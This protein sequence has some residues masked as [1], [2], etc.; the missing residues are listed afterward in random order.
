MNYN[1]ATGHINS[2]E[3][4]QSTVIRG[5]GAVAPADKR[6]SSETCMTEGPY[7]LASTAVKLF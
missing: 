1:K 6:A 2:D 7:D 5:L 3:R 4:A